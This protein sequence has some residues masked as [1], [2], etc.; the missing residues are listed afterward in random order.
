MSNYYATVTTLI[1]ALV[2]LLHAVRLFKGWTV[3][4]GPH[5]VSMTLSWVGLVIAGLLAIWG[6]IETRAARF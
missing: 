6:F 5:S 2:A 4:I 3:Q 1:F